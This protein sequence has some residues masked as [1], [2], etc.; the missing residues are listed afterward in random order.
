M[1]ADVRIARS[2]ELELCFEIRKRVFVDEQEVSREE[3]FDGL[4]AS[5][6]HFIARWNDRVVGTARLLTSRQQAKAQRVAVLREAR[7]AGFGRQLMFALESEARAQGFERVIL[8]AQTRAVPFYEAIDYAAE[9]A[10]F[11]EADIPHRFMTKPLAPL[12]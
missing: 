10:V 11:F 12:V 5:C 2:D 6:V 8:H 7:R 3:E 9:G 4:D 1:H